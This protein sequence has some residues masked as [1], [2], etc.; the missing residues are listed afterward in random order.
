MI[1]IHINAGG[2]GGGGGVGATAR[3]NNRYADAY[4]SQLQAIKPILEETR[5]KSRALINSRRDHND[6]KELT[7][8]IEKF[9]GLMHKL[10]N[11]F[12]NLTD[13]INS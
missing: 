12:D 9:N 2:Y 7:E 3:L 10:N 13:G 8:A 5:S 6:D 1:F 11:M 4:K